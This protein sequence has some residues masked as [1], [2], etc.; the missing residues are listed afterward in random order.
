[1][2]AYS[3]RVPLTNEVDQA[4]SRNTDVE[5]CSTQPQPTHGNSSEKDRFDKA[6]EQM[7]WDL[8]RVKTFGDYAEWEE[9]SGAANDLYDAIQAAK[10]TVIDFNTREEVFGFP[11]TEYP[12]LDT[13]EKE[14]DPFFR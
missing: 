12:V 3:L 1:M 6:I 5:R 7:Q 2:S 10:E 9:N 13:I 11:P 8:R 14:L 4:E